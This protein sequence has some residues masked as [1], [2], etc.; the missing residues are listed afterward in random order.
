MKNNKQKKHM[1]SGKTKE[2]KR[3]LAFAKRNAKKERNVAEYGAA[4]GS[5]LVVAKTADFNRRFIAAFLALVFAISCLVVGVNFAT[6]AEDDPY[7]MQTKEEN[8]LVVSKGLKNN[9]NG[10]YD[11]KLEAYATGKTTTQT[12]DTDVPLDIVLVLDQSGS[13]LTKDIYGGNEAVEKAFTVQDIE[14]NEYYYVTEDMPYR[15]QV[16][17]DTASVY[18]VAK[19]D[20][21]AVTSWTAQSAY[22]W[23]GDDKTS[24]G[25]TALYYKRG[26]TF[27]KAKV[28]RTNQYTTTN[29]S[30]DI[31]DA[32]VCDH[33]Y[34]NGNWNSTNYYVYV[35]H[36]TTEAD[37]I[38]CWHRVYYR[39][40]GKT[41]DGYYYTFFY[42]KD[43]IEGSELDFYYGNWHNKD[44]F[45]ANQKKGDIVNVGG[46]DIVLL[47]DFQS[48]ACAGTHI[49]D[50][51]EIK[52][53]SQNFSNGCDGDNGT[54]GNLYV[55]A[56]A[57]SQYNYLYVNTD[58]I[59][60][61]QAPASNDSHEYNGILYE[62]G[63]RLF[64]EKDGER[65]YIDDAPVLTKTEPAYNG[66]LYKKVINT[67][68]DTLKNAAKQFVKSVGDRAAETGAD[69]RVAVVGFAGN[70]LP[71]ISG[72]TDENGTEVDIPYSHILGNSLYVTQNTGLFVNK[73]FKNYIT[74]KLQ[75]GEAGLGSAIPTN[76]SM[77]NNIT[78]FYKY[79]NTYFPLNSDNNYNTYG[80]RW[81][82]T[83]TATD[84]T[85]AQSYVSGFWS[86][87]N[88]N[89]SGGSVVTYNSNYGDVPTSNNL[90]YY[91]AVTE[92]KAAD[93]QNALVNIKDDDNDSNHV[94]DD[95]DWAVDHID[96]YGGTYMS[97]GLAMAQD[98]FKY[99]SNIQSDGTTRKR[100]VVVFTD[101]QPGGGGD[102]WDTAAANEALATAAKLKGQYEASVYTVGLYPD[103]PGSEVTSFLTALS[104]KSFTSTTNVLGSVAENNHSA[105]YY[106]DDDNGLSHSVTWLRNKYNNRNTAPIWTNTLV[107]NRTI[108]VTSHTGGRQQSEWVDS[109]GWLR[110]AKWDANDNRTGAN[111]NIWQFYSV[112]DPVEQSGNYSFSA[113]NATELNGIFTTISESIQTPTTTVSLTGD[114]VL[115]DIVS[116]NFILP[117][118]LANSVTVRTYDGATSST[119]TS[120]WQDVSYAWDEDEKTLNVTGF[121]FSDKYIATGHSGERIVVTISGIILKNGAKTNDYDS[122]GFMKIPSNTSAS[123][124]YKSADS[125]DLYGAF[126]IPYALVDPYATYKNGMM[127]SKRIAL[128]NSNSYDL[129]L[130]AYSTG[131]TSSEQIPT[132]YVLVVDQSGS[133]STEDVPTSYSSSGTTKNWKVSDGASTYYYKVTDDNGDDHY[134]RVYR[135]RGYMFEYH[136]KD[137]IYSGSCVS[138]LSWFQSDTDQ[139]TGKASQYWYNPSQ[140]TSGSRVGSSS[141][142]RFYPITV[143]ALGGVGYYGI[144]FRYTNIDGTSSYL[145]YPNQPYYKSPTGGLFG[146]GDRWGLIFRYNTCNATCKALTGNDTTQYTYG[147]FLGV[148]T[149]MYVR[150]VLFTRHSDYS[151]LAY[152][153][154]D[155]VEHIL[156]DATY[157]NSSG[158]PVG[159]AVDS[160][161]V[162]TGDGT[163]PTEA[164][165]NGTLYTA[166][167]TITRLAAL[168]ASLKEFVETVA[169]QGVEHRVAIAGFSSDGYYNTELLTGTD[170]TVSNN[171]GIQYD[172]LTTSNYQ[173]ALLAANS[174]TNATLT[175]GELTGGKLKE[176]IDALTANGGT[177]GEYG[178]YMAK[179][180]LG[181]RAS[182]TAQVAGKEMDR[183]KIVVYFTD[184]TPGNYDYSNQYL[185]GN[186]VVDAAAK[187]KSS[188]TLMDTEIY[189]IGTFGFADSEP[190]T[191]QKYSGTDNEYTYDAD[192]VET[193]GSGSS[194]RYLY[195]IWLRNTKGYGDTATD[196]VSDYMRTIS[197]EYPSATKFVDAS[198]YGTGTKSDDGVYTDMV[199]RVR[200]SASGGRHY[201]L[202]TDLSS[203]SRT[204]TTVGSAQASAGAEYDATTILRDTIDGTKFDYSNATVSA[205]VRM[206]DVNG[207]TGSGTPSSTPE[208]TTWENDKQISDTGVVE[209]KGVNYTGNFASAEQSG[210]QLVVTISGIKPLQTVTG[211]T[212]YSNT[213]NSGIYSSGTQVAPFAKPF[214]TRHSYTLDAGSENTDATFTVGT[215]IVYE[216]GDIVN[217]S[218]SSLSSVVLVYPNGIRSRYTT[219]GAQSFSGM[220]NTLPAFYYEGI[221]SGYNVRTNVANPGDSAYTYYLRYDSEGDSA[222]R[223]MNTTLSNDF[224][225]DNHVLNV[226][227]VTNT[228]TVTIKET[229]SGEYANTDD[230]FTPI[231]YLI[232]PTGTTVPSSR[233]IGDYT[234]TKDGDNNR[235]TT[236]LDPIKGDNTESIVLTIPTN[237]TIQ[238][239]NDAGDRYTTESYK[240]NDG[241]PSATETINVVVGSDTTILISNTSNPITITGVSDNDHFLPIWAWALIGVCLA[242]AACFYVLDK[243]KKKKV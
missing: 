10:T 196:T 241:T 91:P 84:G 21:V 160:N 232:P 24:T 60:A 173:N 112:S 94:N 242:A 86:S 199:D 186:K 154:D 143:S 69:H 12:L 85:L 166:T 123:G 64:Y 208:I 178:L 7:R 113:S 139:D 88:Y 102:T 129:T 238:V 65:I 133:M 239:G 42:Y 77:Y 170:L 182:T 214:I 115:K 126:P 18:S 152:K 120:S 177:E 202:C 19:R 73:G 209:V 163:S 97:Y 159:G 140:D 43:S 155:G 230:T 57:S 104:S 188:A 39:E 8:G 80:N 213:D 76:V 132:D 111:D 89:P 218:D 127:L 11:L 87:N 17:H 207:A 45:Q 61:C 14:E 174:S 150:Q 223:E 121:D 194:S 153:D 81:Y 92:L 125:D 78:Y 58:Y 16:D 101:G 193:Y 28:K 131:K 41:L 52:S 63:Y 35:P 206:V 30:I 215:L 26:N 181:N 71:S 147:S 161:G 211:D 128:N 162:P 229:V 66:T 116:D 109:N 4:G 130:T 134:Y 105:T 108:P 100:I 157:C 216:N 74:P 118:D 227:S 192:Y 27:E 96:A 225:F 146:P 55:R 164:Y 70:E 44:Y 51:Y 68:L 145:T 137:T 184:G 49:G 117:A 50:I 191:Y 169:S 221:P 179:N 158:T 22:D 168:K 2:E 47:N 217:Q 136:A 220:G 198:W 114:A 204:F 95:I 1:I 237:W 224:S 149:G 138:N 103:N 195:R 144:R 82:D 203:L 180:I 165:W 200:G 36:D 106:F 83:Y 33:T 59:L 190:L 54:D 142:D 171:N 5:A 176:A 240:V 197:S 13:M 233:D 31:T 122:N 156:I 62:R 212:V 48:C 32:D 25:E 53:G 185:F 210:E 98:V 189:S 56:S 235:L 183:L 222:K 37:G 110:G 75:E 15:V 90:V 40:D 23:P 236:T 107:G 151:Q 93:Y 46:T 226:T 135:K 67:R 20:E 38:S 172:D 228:Q 167:N 201:F 119:T 3:R 9:G 141:D 6:K 99:N 148:N 175:D 231:V 72:Y 234:W 29:N 79:G 124:I 187:I 243:K 219:S 205:T 34:G